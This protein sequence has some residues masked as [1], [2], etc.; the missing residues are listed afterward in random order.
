MVDEEIVLKAT[1]KCIDYHEH[2][3]N[4]RHPITGEQVNI[5]VYILKY[6][7]NE[8]GGKINLVRNPKSPFNPITNTM[9]SYKHLKADF[10]VAY[11]QKYSCSELQRLSN[12]RFACTPQTQEFDHTAIA[13]I[14]YGGIKDWMIREGVRLKNSKTGKIYQT[15]DDYLAEFRA[16]YAAL[17]KEPPPF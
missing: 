17:F 14:A 4:Y 12:N 11:G 7:E 6:L 15:I 5:N 8:Y 10:K 2:P 3:E 1:K 16:S 9:C 13:L